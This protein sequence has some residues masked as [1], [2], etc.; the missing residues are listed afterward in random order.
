M[1]ATIESRIESN[2]VLLAEFHG[3]EVRLPTQTS[4]D[5]MTFIKD[6]KGI[7]PFVIYD[8]TGKVMAAYDATADKTP[9]PDCI[10][11]DKIGYLICSVTCNKENE[12]FWSTWDLVKTHEGSLIIK[13]RVN[14][15]E[16][17]SIFEKLSYIFPKYFEKSVE[18][19]NAQ[20]KGIL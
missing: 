12:Y 17:S 13:N 6:L 3:E 10:F 7:R 9:L 11:S 2:L 5:D 20:Q 8:T 1:Y 14:H 16:R 18:L 15:I 19:T 4:T